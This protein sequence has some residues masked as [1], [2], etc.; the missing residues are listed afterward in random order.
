MFGQESRNIRKT[1]L[2]FSEC[3]GVKNVFIRSCWKKIKQK[4]IRLFIV[5]CGKLRRKWQ[6]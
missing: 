1:K 5:F 2:N 3:K 4:C 6:N